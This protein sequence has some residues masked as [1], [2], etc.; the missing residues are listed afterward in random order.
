MTLVP[1]P[2]IFFLPL[3]SLISPLPKDSFTLKPAL[4]APGL[5]EEIL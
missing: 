3:K 4:K 2:D 5:G 1:K